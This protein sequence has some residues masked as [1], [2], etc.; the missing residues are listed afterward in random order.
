MGLIR[1]PELPRTAKHQAALW[2]QR[3]GIDSFLVLFHR[4]L[5]CSQSASVIH[6]RNIN[7]V[8]ISS[9][10]QSVI[11]GLST[12]HSGAQG[13]RGS[14]RQAS[15]NTPSWFSSS[16]GHGSDCSII[17]YAT[18]TKRRGKVRGEERRRG[19]EERRRG[20]EERRG[21]GRKGEAEGGQEERGGT[22]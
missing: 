8:Q 1:L 11:R 19:E 22:G 10:T 4:H 9:R 14:G 2:E 13:N 15:A 18:N 16:V 12:R 3:C 5:Q 17:Y 6:H 21:E 20:E 7:Y